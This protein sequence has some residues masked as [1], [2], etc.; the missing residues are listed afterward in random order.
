MAEIVLGATGHGPRRQKVLRRR[1]LVSKDSV[2]T[3]VPSAV[4]TQE[5]AH[6]GAQGSPVKGKGERKIFLFVIL[7]II[8]IVEFL[9]DILGL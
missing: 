9:K 6:V 7:K 4:R 8:F 3:A 1:R 2:P 5:P